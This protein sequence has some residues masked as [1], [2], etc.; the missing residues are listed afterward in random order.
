MLLFYEC[1]K[2]T[3]QDKDKQFDPPDKQYKLSE[4][5]IRQTLHDN[6]SETTL[7]VDASAIIAVHSNPDP[8]VVGKRVCVKYSNM[9]SVHAMY[10][11]LH[12]WTMED[13][14]LDEEE[15]VI[16]NQYTISLAQLS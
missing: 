14:S 4:V 2:K 1:K 5:K 8:E 15:F 16:I 10:Q 12:H 6:R 11:E 9:D 3:L 13:F 7:V